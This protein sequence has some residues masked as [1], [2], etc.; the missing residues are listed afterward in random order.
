MPKS[1]LSPGFV[2]KKLMDEYQTNPNRLSKEIGLTQTAVRLITIDKAKISVPVALRLAKYFGTT[3]EYWISLQNKFDLLEA[4]ND[5]ALDKIVKGIKK[6]EMVKK[7]APAAAKK[8]APAKDAKAKASK[9][10]AAKAAASKVKASAAPKKSGRLP[11]EA[12]AAAAG[13]PKKRGRK[14]KAAPAPVQEKPFVP[15]VVLIKKQ[16]TAPAIPEVSDPVSSEE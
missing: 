7:A 5:K 13:A 12:K 3:P 2:L 4:S 10:P 9:K 11:K 14:P 15:H 16:D 1:P 8:A 6:A